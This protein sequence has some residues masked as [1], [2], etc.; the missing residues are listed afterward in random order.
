MHSAP[1]ID[2]YFMWETITEAHEETFPHGDRGFPCASYRDHYLRGRESYPWHWH[3]EW[4]IAFV[5]QGRMS[6]LIND[7]Q[8]TLEPGDG[9][10]INRRMLHA[11]SMAGG[12]EVWMPNLLFLPSLLYGSQE[13]VIWERYVKP[14]AFSEEVSHL[15]LRGDVPWQREAV[16]QAARAHALM[17]GGEYG[18]E[19]R[20]RAALSEFL[21]AVAQRLPDLP[22][23]PLKSRAEVG[24]VRQML[25]FIQAHY[26]QPLRV[27]DIADSAFIS[28][29]ACMRDFQHVLGVSPMQYV[30]ELRVRRAK[31][32]LLETGLDLGDICAACGF[33]GQSYFTKT[34]REKTGV[35]PG[36]FRAEG[37]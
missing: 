33:Q 23:H 11:F 28:R 6:V 4:E 26:T 5:Q 9:I 15:V 8:Q 32:L 7:Q 21:L 31:R 34:F 13:S 12:G 10:F 20:V 22:S 3:E 36:R 25:S 18:Y 19:L 37:K 14:L 30:I 35:T 17:M 27:E 24:R 29:R 16:A 1:Q 2:P